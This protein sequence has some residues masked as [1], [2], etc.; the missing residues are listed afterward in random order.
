MSDIFKNIYYI[1]ML[2]TGKIKLDD[3]SPDIQN[4]L[5]CL[6]AIKGQKG[7]DDSP[8]EYIKN[9]TE[10]ICLVAVKKDGGALRYVENQTEKICLAAVKQNGWSLD[11]VQEQTEEICLAAVKNEGLA[12]QH[13]KNQTEKICIAA[14]KNDHFA[15]NYVENQTNKVCLAALSESPMALMDLKVNTDVVNL[16][17]IRRALKWVYDRWDDSK[18]ENFN[19]NSDELFNNIHKFLSKLS[20]RELVDAINGELKVFFLDGSKILLSEKMREIREKARMLE[21]IGNNDKINLKDNKKNR[22][23]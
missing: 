8:L 13:V 17:H 3:I 4:E 21:I 7:H 20:D 16:R 15:F 5:I 10:A 6:A 22:L 14:V 19:D 12:I 1:F 11:H 2:S 18:P 23:I 9:Q